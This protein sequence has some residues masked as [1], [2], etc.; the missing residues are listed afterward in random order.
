MDFNQIRYFLVL[1]D[2]LHFG[3]ASKAV[4]MAQ[5]HF[6]RAIARLEEELDV[7]LFAR[8]SRR[9]ELTA[10]G[11]AFREEARAILAAEER[12]R[13]FARHAARNAGN[14]L[15]I[16][17][18]SAA[19]YHVLPA[20][21]RS[22]READPAI[23]FD[24]REATTNEQAE[25]IAAGRIDLGLGHPPVEEQPRLSAET[26]SRDRFD[27]VLPADHPLARQPDVDF[28]GLAR[29]PMVLFPE[30]QGPAL[31]AAIRDQCRLAGHP[32]QVAATASRLHSQ[33]SLVSAGL[34]IGL[35][36]VQSRSIDI[37]GTVRRRI[38][39]YP[40]SLTLSLAALYDPRNRSPA[41][42]QALE[43]LK[44]TGPSG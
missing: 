10:A 43:V 34:G 33:L 4:G 27:A 15:R 26:L 13:Q 31:Y 25:L 8:T 38:E 40:A 37:S 30:E 5:P 23:G 35:A 24:L 2:A 9:V 21:I 19:L 29:E 36:P 44:A 39:P 7:R 6:S 42:H 16:A 11:A 22:L 32:L 20:A 41:L 28:A 14:R 17:F 18:V 3:R 12:A 1:A